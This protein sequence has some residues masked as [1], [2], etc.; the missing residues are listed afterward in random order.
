MFACVMCECVCIHGFSYTIYIF[1]VTMFVC[2][3]REC[4]DVCIGFI[5]EVRMSVFV[6][7]G[8]HIQYDTG[9]FVCVGVYISGQY[10]CVSDV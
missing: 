9:M 7:M 3:I 6:Y 1:Q 5:Y 2:V 10:V 4:V 8:V